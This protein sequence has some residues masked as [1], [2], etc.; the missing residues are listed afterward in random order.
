MT[1]DKDPIRWTCPD[2]DAPDVLRAAFAAGSTEGPSPTQMRVLALKL[3]AVSAGAGAAAAAS[4]ASAQAGG[5]LGGTGAFAVGTSVSLGKVAL[6]VAI[7]GTLALSGVVFF[8]R[9]SPDSSTP[10]S[11]SPAVAPEMSAADQGAPAPVDHAPTRG[12]QGAEDGVDLVVSPDDIMPSMPASDETAT[13]P[14]K[15][16]G[17]ANEGAVAVPEA[18]TAVPSTRAPRSD[19]PTRAPVASKAQ[20]PAAVSAVG[21]PS[22][23]PSEV[24]LLRR[25]RA[26]L[27]HQPRDAFRLTESHREHYPRGVFAQE[28]DALAIEAL[29]RAGDLEQARDLAARF[30]RA[31]P[32]S[33]H[34]HRFRE[35]L[36]LR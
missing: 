21:G 33:P 6:S 34:A 24:E 15:Q 30:V 32:G 5:T 25:A 8:G 11:R 35:T 27:N 17:T 4:T 3:A 14:T 9:P 22:A 36:G 10:G 20:A 23:Q 16:A 1:Y 12:P 18:H 26:A 28:R 13:S 29:L 31:H 2:S 7:A 19:R